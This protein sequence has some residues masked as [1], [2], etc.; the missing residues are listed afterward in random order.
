MDRVFLPQPIPPIDTFQPRALCLSM[1][2]PQAGV[3]TALA[4][5]D[6]LAEDLLSAPGLLQTL[7]APRF[8][9]PAPVSQR[10]GASNLPFPPLVTATALHVGFS[11]LMH[12]GVLLFHTHQD[13]VRI[14]GG[15]RTS[16]AE[17][18]YSPS[19]GNPILYVRHHPE[20]PNKPMAAIVLV[21]E[22]DA[23]D[24]T[25]EEAKEAVAKLRAMLLERST[26]YELAGGDMLVWANQ[27]AAHGRTGVLK[28][29]YDGLDRLLVRT[30]HHPSPAAS[31]VRDYSAGAAGAACAAESETTDTEILAE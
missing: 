28:P 20:K 31:V 30:F 9:H 26:K 10:E 18:A 16:L 22:T 27:R 15:D 2:R 11:L 6:D 1:L 12:P 29:N 7:A 13:V 3:Q 4:S 19:T 5:V 21:E 25:D 8:T 17:D 24:P 14:M 23:V